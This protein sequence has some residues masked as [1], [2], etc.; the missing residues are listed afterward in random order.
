MESSGMESLM[1]DRMKSK[2]FNFSD[3]FASLLKCACGDT[4]W[5]AVID[6]EVK[7]DMEIVTGSAVCSDIGGL[8]PTVFLHVNSV[9]N[10]YK[11]KN[12]RKHSYETG[13]YFSGE[14]P[15]R[16]RDT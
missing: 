13:W 7:L 3:E 9:G 14:G 12:L 5:I 10:T 15:F 1:V 2:N 11:V 16:E 8:S 4:P 6:E